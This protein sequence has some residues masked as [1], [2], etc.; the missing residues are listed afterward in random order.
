VTRTS[1]VNDSLVTERETRDETRM[2]PSLS[3]FTFLAIAT[4]AV[5]AC[6]GAPPP[7]AEAPKAPSGAAPAD[8]AGGKKA[9][10]ADDKAT[11][12]AAVEALVADEAKKEK[13]DE[14]HDAALTKLVADAEAT[15]T[16]NGL[17][18][19]VKRV[20][21]LGNTAKSIQLS[22]TGKGTE[23]HV[24]TYAVHEISLDVLV[25]NA[26]ATTLRSP[27]QRTATTAPLSIDIPK[28][29]TIDELQT[30]SR[31]VTI[32]P[33]QPIVVKVSGQGCAAIVSFLKP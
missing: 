27:F 11:K 18:L 1:A 21:P 33:G 12:A 20:T 14:G 24:L 15:M 29:G 6:G 5:V 4:S 32:K 2:R 7:P 17:Q 3:M 8:A 19:V 31:Q 10:A 16:K 23:L 22:V 30:D 25:G 28:I 9:G 13:C 26:A